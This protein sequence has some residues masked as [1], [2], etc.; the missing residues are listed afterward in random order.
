MLSKLYLGLYKISA[1]QLSDINS[2]RFWDNGCWH[3]NLI[4]NRCF[5]NNR[6]DH[7]HSMMN[8]INLIDLHIYIKKIE[9]Y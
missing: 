9:K 5:K 3:W 2:I 8:A 1:Q 4:W 6:N 7:L